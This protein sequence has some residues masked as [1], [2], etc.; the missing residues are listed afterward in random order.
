VVE[1]TT[2]TVDA[3][4]TGEWWVLQC[5]EHAGAIT[6]VRRLEH[7]SHIVEAIA[8]VAGIEPES[9]DIHVEPRLPDD[10]AQLVATTLTLRRQAREMEANV[11]LDMRRSAHRLLAHG[12]SQ[13][14]AA[15]ILGI[16]YQRVHQLVS[17]P[18]ANAG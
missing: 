11:S 14:D 7:A 5:R 12:L 2:F 9:V 13:R 18:L 1:M 15:V 17:E 8:F 16:S 3:E 4:Y 10:V 6:Q